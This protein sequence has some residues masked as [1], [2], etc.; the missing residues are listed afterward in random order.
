MIGIKV[1]AQTLGSSNRQQNH[2][3]KDT[4]HE[5]AND[6][7]VLVAVGRSLGGWQRE[8]LADGRLDG[9]TGRGHEV[10]ELVRSTDDEG[11]NGTRREL[12][13]VNGDHTPGTLHTELLKESGGHDAFVLDEGVGVEEGAADDADR[14]DGEASAK[15]LAG[16]AAECAASQGAQVGD[17]LGD[18]DGVLRELELVAEHSGVQILGAVGLERKMD[19]L[20]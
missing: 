4:A 1:P 7:A 5:D 2:I 8:S 19:M 15:D 11:T 16:P 18:R 3:R 10:T 6:L 13:Q 17:D 9:R 20:E 12:H 14:D